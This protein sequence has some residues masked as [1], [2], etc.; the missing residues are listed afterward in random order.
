MGRKPRANKTTIINNKK[1]NF[2][3]KQIVLKGLVLDMFNYDRDQRETGDSQ[4]GIQIIGEHYRKNPPL[5]FFKDSKH[6]PQ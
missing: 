5:G 3:P 4:L 2:V 1:Y 6:S